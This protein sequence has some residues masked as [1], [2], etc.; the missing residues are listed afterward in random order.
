MTCPIRNRSRLLVGCGSSALALALALVLPHRAEAQGINASGEVTVGSASID[1]MVPG[2][3][4]ISVFSQ[5]AVIDW[6]PAEDVNG[7][8]LDFLPTGTTALFE[9]GE[10]QPD[11][12]ILN[13]I[14]P[15]TNGNI[16]VID[17]TVISRVFDASG[18]TVPGGFVAFYSPTG[19]LIGSNA[20]FDVGSL[21]LTTLEPDAASFQN[22]F[23]NSGTLSLSGV[24]GSTARIQIDAG[25][26]IT[27]APEN[28]F[29]AVVAADV[30]MSGTALVNGSHA[31]VAGEVV[32]LRFSN[33]LFDIEVPVGTA[34][35]G[36]V[37]NINGTVGGP[38]STGAGDNHMIYGVVAA[39]NDP[40]SMIFSG[41]LGFEPAQSAG[42]V[43]GEII[44]SANYNVFGRFVDG[45]TISDGINAVF[46]GNSA[47]STTEANIE[48][49]NFTAT[50]SLL[51]IG[52]H[53][54]AARAV[55]GSTSVLG[56][57]LLV[58]RQSANLGTTFA[59][60]VDV[61]GDVLV[62]ARDY[63]V[64]GSSLQDPSAINAL[65]GS[66]RIF[67]FEDGSITI[68]GDLF[69][70][71]DAFAGAD[72]SSGIAGSARAGPAVIFSNAGT[73]DVAGSARVSA[74]AEGAPLSSV[75]TGAESRG[76]L[77]QVSANNGGAVTIGQ[78]LFVDAS[79]R[80]ANG[81]LSNP[82]SRS[83]AFGGNAQISLFAGGGNITVNGSAQVFAQGLGGSS[84][85]AGAGSIGLGGRALLAINDVGSINILGNV[86]LIADGF[87]G[88]NAGGPGGIGRGNRASAATLGGGTIIVGGQFNAF[89]SGS[90][91][92]GLIGGDGFGGIAG[93]I[94]EIGAIE[95]RGG[96]NIAIARGFGGDATFGFGG[97]GGIGRG[98]NS[99]FQTNGTLTETASLAIAFDATLDSD[100][101]GGRGG[102][103]DGQAIAAGR[104]GDGFGGEA[105]TPNQADPSFNNGAYLLAGADNGTLSVGGFAFVTSS[106]FGGGGG[107]VLGSEPSGFGGNGFGGLAQVGLALLGGD[108]SVGLG[109]ATFN[110][111]SLSAF[112][113]G[114]FGGFEAQTE[115]ETGTGG[116]GTGGSAV[117]TV[118]AGNVTAGLANLNAGGFGGGGV[119]GGDGNGGL[120]AITL[121]G[122]AALD[123]GLIEL[124]SDAETSAGGTAQAGTS[125]LIIIDGSS[126]QVFADDII[127]TSDASGGAP[128]Q[129]ANTAG[130]FVVN[131]GGGN[132]NTFNLS[133]SARGDTL[134]LDPLPS[135]L[136]ADGG[137]INVSANLDAVALGNIQVR[138][139]QGGIIGSP[140]NTAATTAVSLRSEGLIEI[141]GD[142]GT[143]IGLGG[144]EI[145]LAAREID[146][147]DGARIGARSILF[148]SIERDHTAIIG[149]NTDEI[150]FTLTAAEIA[151]IAADNF[152]FVGS[153]VFTEDPNQP[154]V[155]V[156]GFTISGSLDGGFSR[157][158]I[159]PVVEGPG[160]VR[161]EG[162]V[163]YVNAA[164]EDE[165]VIN[166]GGRIEAVTPGGIHITNSDR[167]PGGILTLN[168]DNIWAAD[169]ELIAQ[170]QSDVAFA[171]RDDLLAVAAQGSDDPLGY[172]RAGE[173]SIFVRESLLVRNT[174]IAT[175]QGGILVGGGGLSIAASTSQGEPL[176]VFAYGRRQR[177][178]GS[179]VTGNDFFGEVNFNRTGQSLAAYLALS[180]LNDCIINTGECPPPPPPP[181]EPETPRPS[182]PDLPPLNNPTVI[183]DP[184]TWGEPTGESVAEQNDKF[185][186]N[187]P[188]QPETP[189]ISEEPLLDDPVTSGSDA[190]LYS[191]P[192][193]APGQEK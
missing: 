128:G 94:A 184:V 2:Q 135:Q 105:T 74:R 9:A 100:G 160:I 186:M 12:A 168:A 170:L 189:L 177:D 122:N 104:G 178:D 22:F 151:R 39:Q 20:T 11:F 17:G 15:S 123:A 158:S 141:L 55:S 173:V 152:T 34:A 143:A 82:S 181:T 185:G 149:G 47:T 172:L 133:A 80:G 182:N 7:D 87:G 191:A 63:G 67:T 44:L 78:D 31:Y 61:S 120:A 85:N 1:A 175:G 27:A 90:G 66:A 81:D 192:G 60:T 16:A 98:G 50:S 65:G 79:A 14:L 43:N 93:A 8:A 103:G 5:T 76:G 136:V 119:V 164:S 107:A 21:L 156:R 13:R 6:T 124:V 165:F 25:A 113:I 70:T 30:Q 68:G 129:A 56:N 57:L 125:S 132:L 171:G 52:T 140:T 4:T 150:G 54:T 190:S 36:T 83:N 148:F 127:L 46:N 41:N 35:T 169:A 3:T 188:E 110:D 138:T 131:I 88:T 51:A 163:S 111:V 73:L 62:S 24:S 179:F 97:N 153:T 29:F 102:D 99:F 32:N 155:L 142:D 137:N 147:A 144:D 64:F 95:L 121:Q 48:V 91:G 117:L 187:F 162:T 69:L 33:G 134:A 84:N 92:N 40:I 10:G 58:G 89:A 71:A 109:S 28:A 145:I 19:I 139:G 183:L 37:M 130:R 49:R 157:F 116:N 126:A 176:D 166:A 42:I 174:G 72:D 167:L 96:S 115:S 159:F 45:G 154:D 161:I 146:I 108:G 26:Q 23:E 38:S 118:A 114:G 77:A 59:A 101:F 112:G 86:D 53:N 75:F 106:G 18:N 180:A 193:K